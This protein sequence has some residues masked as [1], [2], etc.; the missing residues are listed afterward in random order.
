MEQHRNDKLRETQT[1]ADRRARASRR[2][3]QS[4]E[5]D[6][7]PTKVVRS[8]S[9][10]RS[11]PKLQDSPTAASQDIFTTQNGS[12]TTSSSDSAPFLS[13]SQDGQD[14]LPSNQLILENERDCGL[15][16]TPTDPAMA[17]DQ[18]APGVF[19]D[20]AEDNGGG[21]FRVYRSPNAGP[22]SPMP[23]TSR[24]PVVPADPP[25]TPAAITYEGIAALLDSK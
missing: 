8:R 5:E 3:R 24:L 9:R 6:T 23:G 11:P 17:T 20:A 13:F 21:D 16:S 19:S 25:H 18:P 15:T 10:S 7:S 1:E 14:I 22:K 4:N 12:D 2:S